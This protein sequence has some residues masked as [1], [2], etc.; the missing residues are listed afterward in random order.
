M[1]GKS[2]HAASFLEKE[3]QYDAF[4]PQRSPAGTF[5]QARLEAER[6]Q[7]RLLPLP[8][9]GKQGRHDLVQDLAK[10]RRAIV[11][12]NLAPHPGKLSHATS[13]RTCSLV[14]P[15]ITQAKAKPARGNS[16]CPEQGKVKDSSK[17]VATT[18]GRLSPLIHRAPDSHDS[19]GGTDYKSRPT[20]GA[21]L[22]RLT[23][24]S[25][26]HCYSTIADGPGD[27]AVVSQNHNLLE[28][29]AQVQS[30]AMSPLR[31]PRDRTTA[32]DLNPYLATLK[33]L[34][35]KP[36][37][38]SRKTKETKPTPDSTNPESQS[39]SSAS[40]PRCEQYGASAEQASDAH[41][42]P[43]SPP[44]GPIS[45]RKQENGLAKVS[46]AV[47]R[48]RKQHLVEMEKL[49]DQKLREVEEL[50]KQAE[51]TT[52]ESISSRREALHQG[53]IKKVRF[54]RRKAQ[55]AA[56]RYQRKQEEARMKLAQKHEEVEAAIQ[57]AAKTQV[58]RLR[59]SWNKTRKRTGAWS[60]YLEWLARQE[61]ERKQKAENEGKRIAESSEE[62]AMRAQRMLELRKRAALEARLRRWK[63]HQ[64][65]ANKV[66]AENEV[67]QQAQAM[68]V[69]E[70][71]NAV[72]KQREEQER[73]RQQAVSQT[74]QEWRTTLQAGASRRIAIR[75]ARLRYL[76][77]VEEQQARKLEAFKWTRDRQQYEQRMKH[78]KK[79]NEMFNLVQRNRTEHLKRVETERR[80]RVE[81]TMKKIA[82]LEASAQARAVEPK[83]VYQM[84]E[85]QRI[86]ARERAIKQQLS[87]LE[88]DAKQLSHIIESRRSSQASVAQT[89]GK[90]ATKR[91][92]EK[93]AKATPTARN[94]KATT[95][96]NS[97]RQQSDE[98]SDQSRSRTHTT[99]LT[100][101]TSPTN[102]AS[103]TT[104]ASPTIASD[105]SS[106]AQRQTS[107]AEE[108]SAQISSTA[109]SPQHISEDPDYEEQFEELD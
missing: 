86:D 23:V 58:E 105:A 51:E 66:Q 4:R 6:S 62:H 71:L 107:T 12:D 68:L 21:G 55:E 47:V 101:M 74:R 69:N 52:M 100:T 73:L 39:S 28:S 30:P 49:L 77:Q 87:V 2:G 7:F 29:I 91:R 89:A 80:T 46:A 32:L 34:S 20:Q 15:P 18:S 63:R 36:K 84:A 56:K 99:A 35:P 92:V 104:T 14:L 65:A 98:R 33:I 37:I 40:T 44:R 11:E 83:K 76:Q 103:S 108:E 72:Q 38:S 57:R 90:Q 8:G 79:R 45:P 102:T 93:S 75:N 106:H 50:S 13:S 42:A 67:L 24:L 31:L 94:N 59:K 82:N 81:E 97:H 26:V 54:H 85:L 9:L 5:N 19:Q 10:S 25:P 78:I 53:Y 3:Y 1:Y 17:G 48:R 95:H 64:K 22:G 109:A 61:A 43:S 70:R 88:R 96:D 16:S 60:K 41:S 27:A